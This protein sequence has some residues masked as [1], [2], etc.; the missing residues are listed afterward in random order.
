MARSG[1][2]DSDNSKTTSKKKDTGKIDT[3]FNSWQ[4]SSNK[5]MKLADKQFR[6]A[7]KQ[8][9]KNWDVASPIIDNLSNMMADYEQY[10]GEDRDWYTGTFKPYTED[11]MGQIEGFQGKADAFSNEVAKLKQEAID[12]GSA[13]NKDF[14]MGAVQASV[15]DQF[16]AAK[17]KNLSELEKFGINPS[18]TRYAALDASLNTAE[19]AAKAAAGTMEGRNVEDT[20][21]Q[22]FSE[23]L[24]RE[25]Q[26]RG[27]D[28]DVL[29]M[30]KG[31]VDYGSDVNKQA[32]SEAQLAGQLGDTAVKDQVAV[33]EL[34]NKQRVS[35]NEFLT[36]TNDALRGWS[37]AI[38]TAEA[39]AIEKQ[40]A[41]AA[42][43][44]GIGGI[45]GTA[46]PLIGKLPFFAAEGG[47]VPTELS[48]SGGAIPDDVNTMLSAKEFVF[49]ENAVRFYGTDRLQKMIAKAGSGGVGGGT[50]PQTGTATEPA[51]PETAGVQ[52]TPRLPGNGFSPGLFV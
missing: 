3:V 10:S 9:R 6:W 43:S 32:A 2:N 34:A 23:A 44:S 40:K 33:S 12:Y 47:E 41:E 20:S 27:L 25:L 37:E 52:P 29:A 11:Y 4:K 31:M 42:S 22:M 14:R 35:T 48:P 15:A 39:N 30:R 28:K 16:A 19:G 21:R 51:I 38:N 1:K 24:D 5:G 45:V 50:G 8:N 26:A 7:K 36:S 49:P 17:Q 13:A 46:L 18:A